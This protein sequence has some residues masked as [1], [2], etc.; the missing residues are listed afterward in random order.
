MIPT[1]TLKPASRSFTQT[2]G[3]LGNCARDAASNLI[4]PRLLRERGTIRPRVVLLTRV[5]QPLHSSV[6]AVSPSFMRRIG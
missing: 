3:T 5:P 4:L 2:G 1:V 6:R